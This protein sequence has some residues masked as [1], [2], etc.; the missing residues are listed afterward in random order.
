[1]CVC[2]STLCMCTIISSLLLG[3]WFE[4]RRL[5]LLPGI[6]EGRVCVGAFGEGQIW[7]CLRELMLLLFFFF[8]QAMLAQQHYT[9]WVLLTS[10]IL[11]GNNFYSNKIKRSFLFVG[12]FSLFFEPR[13]TACTESY[14]LLIIHHLSKILCFLYTTKIENPWQKET[15]SIVKQKLPEVQYI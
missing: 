1:M 11:Y 5:Y 10:I 8:M 12:F 14:M 7:E 4:Q 6:W 15:Q 2:V 9:K 3:L 13:N